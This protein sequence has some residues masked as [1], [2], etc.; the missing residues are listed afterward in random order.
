MRFNVRILY[1]TFI[2]FIVYSFSKRIE[3]SIGYPVSFPQSLPNGSCMIVELKNIIKDQS[4]VI[5]YQVIYNPTKFKDTRY[6]LELPGND[7]WQPEHSLGLGLF[8]TVNNGWCAGEPQKDKLHIDD[9][10]AK[11]QYVINTRDVIAGE[12]VVCGPTI[13]FY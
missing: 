10:V 11:K 1:L 12:E 5:T 7:I 2:R 6:E 9:F 4:Y 8:A 3:G 13:E